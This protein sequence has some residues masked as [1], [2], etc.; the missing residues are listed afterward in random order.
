MYL[1]IIR[2][3]GV[4]IIGLIALFAVVALFIFH[5]VWIVPVAVIASFFMLVTL[6]RIAAG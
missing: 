5:P 1:E 6:V 4:G 3:L 2:T